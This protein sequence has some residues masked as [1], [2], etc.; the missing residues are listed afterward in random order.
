M[1]KEL[2]IVKRE[3]N[4]NSKNEERRFMMMKGEEGR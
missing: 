1:S 3:T 2:E 4:G